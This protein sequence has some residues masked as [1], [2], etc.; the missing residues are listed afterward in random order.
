M[1]TSRTHISCTNDGDF[2]SSHAVRG[3]LLI[4]LIELYL[5]RFGRA[6]LLPLPVRMILICVLQVNEYEARYPYVKQGQ[7]RN[8]QASFI[9]P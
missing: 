6:D 4:S 5:I 7:K 1:G 8:L 2:R 3:P 9:T